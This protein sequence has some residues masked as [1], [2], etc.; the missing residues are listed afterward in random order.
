MT[1]PAPQHLT[2][3]TQLGI[4]GRQVAAAA[5]LFDGGATVPFVAR[6]RKE[7]TGCLDEVALNA[8]KDHLARHRELVK[9][10]A[11]VLDSLQQRELLTE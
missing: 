4:A 11:A 6:Y 10:R 3:A 7:V 9:R 2:I 1:S 8:I 5:D